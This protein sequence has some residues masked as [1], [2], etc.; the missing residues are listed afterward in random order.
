MLD[1]LVHVLAAAAEEA[2]ALNL[3]RV[4]EEETALCCQPR[5]TGAG[6]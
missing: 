2:M 6:S 4:A 5:F 3:C 1:D